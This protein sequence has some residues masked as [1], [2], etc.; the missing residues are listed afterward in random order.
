MSR[1]ARV[2]KKYRVPAKRGMLV[3]Y[4]GEIGRI[5]SVDDSLRLRVLLDG[6]KV[7]LHPTYNVEYLDTPCPACGGK[8]RY[9]TAGD[10]WDLCYMCDGLGVVSAQRATVYP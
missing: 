1:M 10:G 5:L 8:G 3:R 9:D 2:R 7:I 4:Y 6:R